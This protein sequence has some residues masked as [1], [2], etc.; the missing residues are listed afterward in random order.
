[1]AGLAPAILVFTRRRADAVC[2]GQAAHTAKRLRYPTQ[3]ASPQAQG[4]F[5]IIIGLAEGVR[6]PCAAL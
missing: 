3:G 6:S 5:P 2:A 4:F 1:M